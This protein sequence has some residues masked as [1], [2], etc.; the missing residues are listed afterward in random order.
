MLQRARYNAIRNGLLAVAAA[1]SVS[2]LASTAGAQDLPPAGEL[3]DRY[4]E[5]LG[6][7]EAILANQSSH[8]TGNFT[9]PAAGMTG[10]LEIYSGPDDQM[11]TIIT[12][13]GLGESRSGFNG[14]VA[15]SVD[16]MM[17]PR[18]LDGAELEAMQDQAGAEASL[19]DE[20]LFDTRE[21]VELTEMNGEACYKVRLQWKSGRETY[22]CFS[23]ESGLLIG[24]VIVQESPMGAVEVTTFLGDYKQFGD[25]WSPTSMRQQI[26]GQEQTMTIESIEFGDLD[27]ALFELPEEIKSLVGGS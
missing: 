19:R 22:D 12:I 15:W 8:M 23:V 5:A 2:V 16:P 4:V 14:E 6:G 11:L 13:P 20:S 17:G 26:M 21:T 1:V 3:I 18:V 7:R 24:T 10:G 9:V 25:L 27:P